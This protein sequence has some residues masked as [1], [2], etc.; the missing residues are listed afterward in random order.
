[1]ATSLARTSYSAY[2]ATFR[3]MGVLPDLQLITD[4]LGLNPTQALRKGQR[5]KPRC[6]LNKRITAGIT[7]LI[8]PEIRA[9]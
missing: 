5:F 1:M 2:S 6:L 7:G 3:I 8:L 9:S 4:T